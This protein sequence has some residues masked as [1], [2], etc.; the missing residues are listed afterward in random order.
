MPAS[1]FDERTNGHS[2][3]IIIESR[4]LIMSNLQQAITAPT[5]RPSFTDLRQFA[6]DQTQG[7]PMPAGGASG[8]NRFLSSRRI[9]DLPPGPVTVG[10]I[11]LDAGSGVVKAQ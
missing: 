9:L 4:I 11:A 8:E 7:I 5:R 2:R 3:S 6:K 10:A 1:F